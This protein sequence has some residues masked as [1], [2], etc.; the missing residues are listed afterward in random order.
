MTQS[1]LG[2]V[3]RE[4][5]VG[6]FERLRAG[7]GGRHEALQLSACGKLGDDALEYPVTDDRTRELL[8]QRTRERPVQDA[9]DLGC[10]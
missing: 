6:E 2:L 1:V 5:S 4:H 7:Q 3:A 10:R 8:R 9:S